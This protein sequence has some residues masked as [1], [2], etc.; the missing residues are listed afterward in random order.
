MKQIILTLLS[1]WV[2]Q[3]HGQNTLILHVLDSTTAKPVEYAEIILKKGNNEWDAITDEKGTYS[4]AQLDTGHYQIY[5]KSNFDI[6]YYEQ[7]F[8]DM[9]KKKNLYCHLKSVALEEVVITSKMFHKESD[10]LVF[11]VALSPKAKGNNAFSLLKETPLVSNT[12][13][14]AFKILGTS[15]AVIYVNG[16]KTNMD[17]EATLEYLKN[18]PSEQIQKIEVITN[19]GSEYQ[20]EA[21]EGIINIVLKRQ[22]SDGYN[23]TIKAENNLGY[24][25]NYGG[26]LNLNFR[27]NKFAV[28]T[29]V[30]ASSYKERNN[31]N[32][33]N[34]NE[35]FKNET[36]GFVSDPNLNFGTQINAEYLLSKRHIL[37]ANYKFRYNKSF[38]SVL[39]VDNFTNGIP[40]SHTS[41]LE[42]AETHNNLFSL[43]YEWKTDSKGSKLTASTT[44]LKYRR[45]MSNTNESTPLNGGS[46]I[47][48]KQSAPH[49]ITN[50]GG[51]LDYKQQFNDQFSFLTGG[52]IAFTNTDNDTRQEDLTEN[53]YV[54]N[55]ALSNHF[56][57]KEQII[58]GYA[59]MESDFGEKITV[60]LGLRLEVTQSDG[61]VIGKE[62]EIKR[63]YSNLLPY[64][65][66]NYN[67]NKENSISYSFS[68]RVKRPTF[69]ELNPSRKYFTPSNYIQ[70]NPFVLPS[71]YYNQELMYMLHNE[72]F[73]TLQYKIVN[74]AFGQIPMQGVMIDDVTKE[75]TRF[76]RYIRTNYGSEKELSLAI[77]MNKS[78]F[79]GFWSTNY[80]I[81]CDFDSYSGTVTK[82][83]TYFPVKGITE[84]LFPYTVDNSNSSLFLQ[85]NNTL[86]LSKNKN[87]FLGIDYWY[88][89]P[90]QIEL[91][92]LGSQQNLSLSV[93]KVW[94]SW[95]I[96]LEAEDIF[97]TQIEK[98]YGIQAD[99]YYNNITSDEYNNQFT[100]KITYNFGNKK[101]KKA[102]EVDTLDST[103]KGRL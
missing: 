5:V 14:T 95:T 64:A 68:S 44:L 4:F 57:Y 48:L 54:L 97:H 20:V 58:G 42:N 30:N 41:N 6:V 37:G 87:W 1:L 69:W 9:S 17:A 51:L 59:A 40:V 21:N 102:R 8:L 46:Y 88:M 72:Y 26:G 75:E 71:K 96:L 53:G 66:F 18:I 31:Y 63:K 33:S 84:V 55:T 22:Q 78:W 16:R 49:Y 89:S 94:E 70:N 11:D 34:G 25:Y 7:F 45:L 83:P 79:D 28:N 38:G 15:D 90:K 12:S 81:N 60:K 100:L 13:G 103:I 85:F 19:P 52:S 86:R 62:N 32:L 101:L 80:L 23:G 56:Q 50:M 3:L 67:F 29:A 39:S 91:G 61:V 36:F 35:D 82:D 73:A 99:G 92:R 76:L 2:F 47:A 98:I 77:G 65:G 24:Y 74:D 43:N 93:R 10:R 27:R